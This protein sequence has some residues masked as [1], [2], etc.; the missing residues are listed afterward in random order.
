MA[1]VTNET[2]RDKM[3]NMS[4]DAEVLEAIERVE[5]TR[6]WI[7][8]NYAKLSAKYQGKVFAVKDETVIES[9]DNVEHLLEE[10]N[11][12]GEDTALLVIESIPRKG[13]AYIL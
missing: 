6:H 5:K 1:N 13:V 3:A 9:N 2:D 4:N 7:A 10:V 12:K 11:K 8:K